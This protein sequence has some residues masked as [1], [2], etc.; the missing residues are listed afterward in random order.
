MVS[1]YEFQL[2]HID[3]VGRPV[4]SVGDTVYYEDKYKS[5]IPTV[6]EFET[7]LSKLYEVKHVESSRSSGPVIVYEVT[8]IID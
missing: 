3:S 5:N 4:L 1:S 6:E 7:L 8:R 2:Q